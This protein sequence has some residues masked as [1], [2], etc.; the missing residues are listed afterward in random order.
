MTY[1]LEP[2]GDRELLGFEPIGAGAHPTNFDVG[3]RVNSSKV[4]GE[5]Y[6]HHS[7]LHSLA[8]E[9]PFSRPLP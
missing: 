7:L 6:R 4:S 1:T 5:P 2:S 9:S 8:S 3:L